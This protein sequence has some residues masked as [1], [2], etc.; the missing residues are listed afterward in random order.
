[1]FIET[2]VKPVLIPARRKRS[3]FNLSYMK[4]N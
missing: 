3:M 1:M 4:E 2:E